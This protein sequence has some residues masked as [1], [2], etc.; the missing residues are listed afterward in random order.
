M[1]QRYSSQSRID[2]IKELEELEDQAW[3]VEWMDGYQIKSYILQLISIL[4]KG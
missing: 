3:N 4:K 1:T 2:M